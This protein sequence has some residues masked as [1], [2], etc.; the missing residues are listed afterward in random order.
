[1]TFST[2]SIA[3]AQSGELIISPSP[4][5]NLGAASLHVFAFSSKGHLLLCESEGP[6]T[7]DTWNQAHDEAQQ[8]CC[9]SATDPDETVMEDDSKPQNLQSLLRSTVAGQVE[10]SRQWKTAT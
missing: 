2:V 3:V 9:K 7:M 6:F 10:R 4:K 8:I 1:M 5:A